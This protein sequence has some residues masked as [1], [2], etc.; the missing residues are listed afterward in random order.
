MFW[1]GSTTSLNVASNRSTYCLNGFG[2]CLTTLKR[3]SVCLGS[4]ICNAKPERTEQKNCAN[5]LT[6][7]ELSDA[8]SSNLRIRLCKEG[9]HSADKATWPDSSTGCVVELEVWNGELH[10]NQSHLNFLEKER[11]PCA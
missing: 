4:S 10:R 3:L 6:L 2:G 1:S 11:H 9:H 8:P 5:E 7:L